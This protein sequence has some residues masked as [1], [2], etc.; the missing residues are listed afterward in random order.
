MILISSPYS[1]LI[2]LS[3]V[4]SRLLLLLPFTPFTQVN[5]RLLLL[6]PFTPFVHFTPIYSSLLLYIP[7]YA[8]RIFGK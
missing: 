6:P 5:S 1:S 8:G 2:L 7:I 3:L 4:Y